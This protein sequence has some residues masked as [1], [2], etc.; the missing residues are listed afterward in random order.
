MTFFFIAITAIFSILAFN[1]LE[2]LYKYQFNAYQITKRKQFLRLLLHG[3]LHTN[4][5]H[6]IVNMIV[7][8]SFGRYLEA[9]FDHIFG[10][11]SSVYFSLLYILGILISPVYALIKHRNNFHYNAVGASGA[12]SAVVFAS[13][14]LEPWNKIYFF[15]LLPMPGILFAVLY[16]LYCWQMAKK[17]RDN[18]AHD[19][20]FAGAIF[21][22]VFPI[23]LNPSLFTFF[24]DQ[25]LG[26]MG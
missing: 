9:S 7:L 3:F 2:I 24:I 17:S 10:Q 11:L 16:L 1:R 19:T 12:V 20:H 14:L 15:G 4:W 25:L 8:Y 5:T 21:G 13:I 26:G 18:V 23:L 6:L 22:L